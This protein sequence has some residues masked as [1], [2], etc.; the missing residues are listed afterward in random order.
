MRHAQDKQDLEQQFSQSQ[1]PTHNTISRL[2]VLMKSTWIL[3]IICIIKII[4]Q[5]GVLLQ[6]QS[7]TA[8]TTIN[9]H[10]TPR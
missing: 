3:Y 5:R 1:I 4:L 8:T 6:L 7:T 9:L 2:R 10:V